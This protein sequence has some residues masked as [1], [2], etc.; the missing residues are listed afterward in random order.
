M[1]DVEPRASL[2]DAAAR[3]LAVAYSDPF[4]T[5]AAVRLPCLWATELL[6]AVGADP[7][8]WRA[9]PPVDVPGRIGEALALLGQLPLDVFAEHAVLEA[10]A[11]A[12]TALDAA[13]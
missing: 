13:G 8:S 1:S 4:L 9:F 6:G 3:L 7:S 2:D 10:A 5:P 11:A 12:R